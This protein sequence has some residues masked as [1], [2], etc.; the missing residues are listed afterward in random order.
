MAYI[1]LFGILLAVF[2]V[3][4]YFIIQQKAAEDALEL[5]WRACIFSGAKIYFLSIF[6]GTLST[7]L[8][9]NAVRYADFMSYLKDTVNQVFGMFFYAVLFTI[10]LVLPFLIIGIKYLSKTSLKTRHKQIWFIAVN[11][12]LVVV[13][14]MI[15]SGFFSNPDFLLFLA[16]YS[17]FGVATPWAYVMSRRFFNT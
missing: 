14:N 2:S 6:L 7:S 8:V 4:G 9:Q 11:T 3:V 17:F 12:F 1:F 13:I 16:G 5:S 10:F 15:M